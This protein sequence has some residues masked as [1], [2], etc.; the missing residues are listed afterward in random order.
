MIRSYVSC[1]Y[2]FRTSLTTERK[3]PLSLNPGIRLLSLACGS[4]SY[5]AYIVLPTIPIALGARFIQ[6]GLVP[7][8]TDVDFQPCASILSYVKSRDA[9]SL[10]QQS[11][12][13]T[14]K[15]PPCM[16]E[17]GFP[18]SCLVQ[19]DRCLSQPGMHRHRPYLLRCTM[20]A[21]CPSLYSTT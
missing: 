20:Y 15:P 21:L 12:A 4:Y 14:F 1:E 19:I 16:L 18:P 11:R 2:L 5:N 9:S 10:I 8:T 7:R 13:S 3:V 17:V 6:L